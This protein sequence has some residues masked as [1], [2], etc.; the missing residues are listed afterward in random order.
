MGTWLVDSYCCDHRDDSQW[1]LLEQV[2]LLA[3]LSLLGR[4]VSRKEFQETESD[5]LQQALSTVHD[6]F[7]CE[8]I[9]IPCSPWD[10]L[11]GRTIWL[12]KGMSS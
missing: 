7:I 3:E 11:N 4:S 12:R 8:H 10:F 1:I 2:S 9:M 6:P 5:I